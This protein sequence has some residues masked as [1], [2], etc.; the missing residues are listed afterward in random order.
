MLCPNCQKPLHYYNY[1]N[2]IVDI[3]SS[4]G[5]LWF[6]TQELPAYMETFSKIHEF[7]PLT[8]TEVTQKA[9]NIYTLAEQNKN[10]PQCR[11]PM[12]KFN[13][14][15]N[16][17]IFL[18]RCLHCQGIWAD[19][20]EITKLV[21]FNQGHPLINKLAK[22]MAGE[23]KDFHQQLDTIETFAGLSSRV[24][25]FLLFMP[26]IILPLTDDNPRAVFPWVTITLIGL[27]LAVFLSQLLFIPLQSW[28]VFYQEFGLIPA[29][30]MA[31]EANSTLFTAIFLHG[32]LLHLLGN[33]LF[34]WLFGDNVEET[35]G[36][37]RF[38]L[39]YLACGLVADFGHIY[40]NQTSTVPLIGASGAISGIMGAYLILFPKIKIKTLFFFKMIN[41]PAAVFFIGWLGL[42]FFNSWL[43]HLTNHAS[44]AWWAH[45]WGFVCGGFLVYFFKTAK[46]GLKKEQ[47]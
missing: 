9:Q 14:A 4:C 45:I 8:L 47:T 10:C 21:R 41:I 12:N 43:A 5:G 27:N 33:M 44:I 11:L 22:A 6:D 46:I 2:I 17:N 19:R 35:F 30:F 24:S 28:P 20:N 7:P 26:K 1:H 13:Y 25:L 38:L 16:S 40:F 18:D 37:I 39:F 15:Y 32:G 23:Q 36:A 42:Q 34:L 31:G 29:R 3:C